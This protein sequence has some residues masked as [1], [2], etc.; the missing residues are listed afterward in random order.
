EVV[1]EITEELGT[2]I[3]VIFSID[4]PPVTTEDIAAA[5]GTEGEESVAPLAAGT[6]RFTARVDPRSR[7]RPKEPIR[8]TV[9]P[10]SLHFFDPA[11]GRA[12]APRRTR[13]P[14]QP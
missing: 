10:A 2:E 12:V 11:T 13:S 5:E 9:D 14:V 8:L 1:P 3:H 4:A 7:V 6:A